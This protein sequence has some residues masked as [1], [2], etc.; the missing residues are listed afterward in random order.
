MGFQVSSRDFIERRARLH[1]CCE[2]ECHVVCLR[3]VVKTVLPTTPTTSCDIQ[4]TPYRVE[5]PLL[6]A[7]SAE[8][9]PAVQAAASS[10]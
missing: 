4:P 10:R 9:M 2:F 3:V 5:T 7:F 6:Q 1:K 8:S